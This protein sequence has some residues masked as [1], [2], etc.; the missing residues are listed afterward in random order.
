MFKKIYHWL[1]R[2]T[3]R[4][5]ISFLE[6]DIKSLS[7]QIEIL[8]SKIDGRG[9]VSVEAPPSYKLDVLDEIGRASIT[10]LDLLMR[11]A[12]DNKIYMDRLEQSVI[13]SIEEETNT[14]DLYIAYRTQKAAEKRGA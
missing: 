6:A 1:R 7:Q 10:R 4:E 8:S 5:H 3:L 11:Y 9:T 12:E 13:K 2:T 14:L